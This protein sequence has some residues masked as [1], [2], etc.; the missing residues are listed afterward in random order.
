MSIS[1]TFQALSD[2]TRRQIL[3]LLKKK[4]M[5]VSRIAVNFDIAL[6]SLSHHLS[7]LKQVNLVSSRRKGQEMIYSL[8]LRVFEET[9]KIIFKIF[10]K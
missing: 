2:T 1:K 9:S 5:S 10:K 3:D 7:V 8:N 6:P 4:E